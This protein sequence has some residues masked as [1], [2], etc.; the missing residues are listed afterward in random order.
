MSSP[1]TGELPPFIRRRLGILSPRRFS[2][3]E[4]V[5]VRPG[6]FLVADPED[7][8]HVLL[9]NAANYVKT[10]Q[11]TSARGRRRAG[12]GVLTSTG[13][14]HRERKRL[15]QPLFH[16]A[17]VVGFGPAMTGC[18]ESWLAARRSGERLDL[19]VEMAD[20][21][22]AA[23]LDILLGKADDQL[24]RARLAHAIHA[25]RRYTEY[26]YWGRLPLRER[27]PTRLVREHA[28]ALRDIDQAI[29]AAIERARAA[30]GEDHL[31]AAL[32]ALRAPDGSG[33]SDRAVRDE[34]LAFTSTG[35]ETLGETLTWTW[36]LLA[37]HPAIEAQFHGGLE[38]LEGRPP[39]AADWTRLGP[40]GAILDEA[41]RLYPPTWIYARIPLTDDR[42]PGGAA[43]RAGT[44]LYICPY[45]LHRHP[46]HFPH[47]E[48]FDPRRFANEPRP[49]RFSYLPFGD[50]P[51]RCLGENLARL[52]GL[53]ALA[54][55]GQRL[56]FRLL[57]D[58]PVEPYGGITLRPRGGLPA[59]VEVR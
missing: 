8:R 6:R 54:A 40:A 26:L 46:H 51:H 5:R 55:I 16:R 31:L 47:P 50:G 17:V 2:Y 19:M 25:R 10:P 58:R 36:Y 56:R 59:E 42:L 49:H 4:L 21:T 23:I 37:R 18:I 57:E 29:F 20:L 12:E 39:T 41:L 9:G 28:A 14:A 48:Q 24:E 15:L 27:L 33:L 22:R 3:N 43:V 35:Y 13:Q 38:E 30:E 7:V 1:A 34:V 53:L 52:E 44:A 11:L 45:I 32:L